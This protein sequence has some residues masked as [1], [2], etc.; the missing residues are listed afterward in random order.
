[1]RPELMN[2]FGEGICVCMYG[3]TQ[4]HLLMHLCVCVCV[5]MC[6]GGGGVCVGVAR[7]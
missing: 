2:A 7:P 4:M 1:M 3:G 6:V 5:C